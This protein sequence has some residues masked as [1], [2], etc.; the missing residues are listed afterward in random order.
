MVG[1]RIRS[2][3]SKLPLQRDRGVG[4]GTPTSTVADTLNITVFRVN[5]QTFVSGLW[6]DSLE[7][8]RNYMAE[9]RKKGKENGMDILAVRDGKDVSVIQ[10]GF[11]PKNRGAYTGMYSFGRV[12]ADLLGDNVLAAFKIDTSTVVRVDGASRNVSADG[13]EELYALIAILD[14]S[15]VADSDMVGDRDSIESKQNE[16]RNA[17]VGTNLA[18]RELI[19]P[20]GWVNADKT[21]E[22][23]DLITARSL[24][25][26]HQLRPLT[27]G[28]SKKEITK[29]AT[30]STGSFI[31]IAGI[32]FLYAH[33]PFGTHKH[34]KSAAEQRLDAQRAAGAGGIVASTKTATGTTVAPAAHDW[35]SVPDVDGVVSACMA[36]L[37]AA[38]LSK[39]GW[40]LSEADC[41]ASG[42]IGYVYVRTGN[43]TIDDFRKA[44][45]KDD[46]VPVVLM[47]NPKTPDASTAGFGGSYTIG[48]THD[49]QLQRVREAIDTFVAHFQ[50][51]GVKVTPTFVDP[52]A[53]TQPA[54][55]P[56]DTPP[57]PDWQTYTFTIT[58][59]SG[60]V[61]VRDAF[62]GV[63]APGVRVNKITENFQPN[64][65]E[66]TYTIKG[67][68]YAR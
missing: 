58:L 31:A 62:N 10:A 23:D 56:K 49:D 38:K 46:H 12:M 37:D 14:G 43:W 45:A 35:A 20:E 61:M 4:N 2:I 51:L 67:N 6:W 13:G 9:A 64:T 44:V 18:W 42:T 34:H 68:L 7:D 11:A 48:P 54:A 8:P 26:E 19:A 15:I 17:V 40:P 22:L 39:G 59:K 50:R 57:P 5:N 41:D 27:F 24:K 28:L 25:K 29:Y 16:L 36:R 63:Q 60:D 47:D 3:A 53:P 55:D 30:I 52:P 32:W 33:W 1:K 66:M 21:I 65:G